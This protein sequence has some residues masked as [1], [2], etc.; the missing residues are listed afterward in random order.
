V[1]QRNPERAADFPRQIASKSLSDQNPTATRLALIRR[2]L[3]FISLDNG[4]GTL[5]TMRMTLPDA[6]T[7]TAMLAIGIERGMEASYLRLEKMIQV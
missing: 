2:L 5:I 3:C 7:W 4:S 6:H 1:L